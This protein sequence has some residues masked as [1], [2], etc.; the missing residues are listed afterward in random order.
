MKIITTIFFT[1]VAL[2]I[3]LF[4]VLTTPI[5]FKQTVNQLTLENSL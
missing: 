4:F 3:V 1:G 5:A 2:S